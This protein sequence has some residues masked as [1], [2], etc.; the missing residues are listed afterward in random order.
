MIKIQGKEA[1]KHLFEQLS[2]QYIDEYI[3]EYTPL[4]KKDLTDSDYYRDNKDE[5]TALEKKYGNG[6]RDK[7]LAPVYIAG[8]GSMGYGLYASDKIHCGDLIGAYMGIIKEEDEM[9]AYDENGYDTDYA[10]DY[11]DEFEGEPLLEINGKYAGNELRFVNHQS[12]ANLRGEHTVV[13][14]Q[15][16]IF[17]IADRDIEKDEQLFISYGEAYWDTDLRDAE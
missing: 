5:F 11:P 9:V 7:H 2:V 4:L 1:I 10:W 3:V 16:Y 17:F 8:A 12:P 15:W 6:I 13:D 14:N